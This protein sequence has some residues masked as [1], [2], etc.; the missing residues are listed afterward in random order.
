MLVVVTGVAYWY[1][2]RHN[3]TKHTTTAIA[4]A[5][6]AHVCLQKTKQYMYAVVVLATTYYVIGDQACSTATTS[7]NSS[8]WWQCNI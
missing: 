7:N 5:T 2:C 8:S 1:C 6:G 3:C 4:T